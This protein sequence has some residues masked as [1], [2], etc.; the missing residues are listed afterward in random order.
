MSQVFYLN[1]GGTIY[2]T[3]RDTLKNIPYFSAIFARWQDGKAND[4][5]HPLFIDQDAGDFRHLLKW[6][7]NPNYKVPLETEVHFWGLDDTIKQELITP[8]SKVE[9]RRC[10]KCGKKYTDADVGVRSCNRH[11]AATVDR[12]SICAVCG[13]TGTSGYWGDHCFHRRD[14]LTK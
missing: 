13:L 6:S 11:I 1:I 10:Y 9:S 12:T 14:W 5:Q 8:S 7:R 4:E 3:T 2:Q